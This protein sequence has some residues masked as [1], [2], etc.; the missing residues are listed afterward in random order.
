MKELLEATHDDR[1]VML[2][3]RKFSM[4]YSAGYPESSAFRKA[5]FSTRT[6]QETYDRI[7]DYYS[8]INLLNKEDTSHEEFLMGGHG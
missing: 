2:Q 3:L 7:L 8:N 6:A 4:W 1:M 5:I